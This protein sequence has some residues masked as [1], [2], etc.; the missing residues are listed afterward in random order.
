MR[1]VAYQFCGAL[2][3]IAIAVEGRDRN[4]RIARLEI[5][6]A[7]LSLWVYLCFALRTY[8]LFLCISK[9]ALMEHRRGPLS[10]PST[11]TIAII[12]PVGLAW[13]VNCYQGYSACVGISVTNKLLTRTGAHLVYNM[14]IMSSIDFV[15]TN[16]VRG[17]QLQQQRA[18]LGRIQG[19]QQWEAEQTRTS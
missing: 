16:H 19:Q 5:H 6:R 12:L 4:G 8:H 15:L 9:Q 1:W 14:P 2:V 18:L 11:S 10:N 3:G 7:G 17:L 13:S